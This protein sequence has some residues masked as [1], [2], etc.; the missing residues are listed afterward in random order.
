ML[1]IHVKSH[2]RVSQ[3][4]Q[5][6]HVIKPVSNSEKIEM[7]KQNHFQSLKPK[8]AHKD[9]FILIQLRFFLKKRKTELKIFCPIFERNVIIIQMF[10]NLKLK[11]TLKLSQTCILIRAIM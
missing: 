9:I 6:I 1:A 4:H 8:Q 10:I 5:I 11:N 7:S 2:S 3:I